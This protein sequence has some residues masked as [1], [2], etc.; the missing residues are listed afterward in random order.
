MEDECEDVD[1]CAE[2]ASVCGEGRCLNTEGGY[3]CQCKDGYQL[4]VDGRQCV[5]NRRGVCYNKVNSG[6]YTMWDVGVWYS[7][8]YKPIE[9]ED[10]MQC[11][12]LYLPLSTFFFF[13][14]V[15]AVDD[16]P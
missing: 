14:D 15:R 4:T 13:V 11:S 5:D 9:L 16:S 2:D 10:K 12:Y 7:D 8:T 1:E 6:R 3:Q